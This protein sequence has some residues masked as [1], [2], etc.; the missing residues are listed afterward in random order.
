MTVR[1][2][3]G[4]WQCSSLKCAHAFQCEGLQNNRTS[5]KLSNS[6]ATPQSKDLDIGR[7]VLNMETT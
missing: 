5:L 1:I 4:Q 7:F 6:F 3:E 2:G